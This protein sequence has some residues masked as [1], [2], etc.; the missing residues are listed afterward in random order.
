MIY[1]NKLANDAKVL[2]W[3]STYLNHFKQNCKLRQKILNLVNLFQILWI[4]L[5]IDWFCRE[6]C[7]STVVERRH[8]GR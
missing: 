4:L 7:D 8:R 6:A 5:W 2:G 1:F 3:Q